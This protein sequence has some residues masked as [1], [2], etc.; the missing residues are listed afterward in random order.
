[1]EL[2]NNLLEFLEVHKMDTDSSLIGLSPSDSAMNECTEQE[3]HLFQQVVGWRTL[4]G[5]LDGLEDMKQ[6]KV[7]GVKLVYKVQDV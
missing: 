2:A 4:E 1:M 7:S 5:I 6:D 3:R